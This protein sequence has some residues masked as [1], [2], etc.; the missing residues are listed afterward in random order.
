MSH[1]TLKRCIVLNPSTSL[2]T[3]EDGELHS[4]LEV[5]DTMSKLH[6]ALFDTPLSNPDTVFF[7][8][9]CTEHNVVIIYL[10]RLPN[11]LH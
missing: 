11:Y 2:P 5:V 9:I 3:A 7:S 4:C 8:A 10:L 1:V 6:E